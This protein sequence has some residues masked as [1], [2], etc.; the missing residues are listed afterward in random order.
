MIKIP[1]LFLVAALGFIF[2]CFGQRQNEL[3]KGSGYYGDQSITI[4]SQ[5]P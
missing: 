1:D 2:G 3:P 5:R 4:Q